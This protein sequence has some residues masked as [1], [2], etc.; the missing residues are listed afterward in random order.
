MTAAALIVA[1]GRG[2]RLGADLPKQ[3]IPLN[4]PCALRRSIELF[5]GAPGIEH[6]R[7]VI[8]PEDAELYDAAVETLRDDR[9]GPPVHGGAT[10]AASVRAGL[11]AMAQTPPEFVL[12]H[13]AARPFMP[14]PVI[15][16]VLAALAEHEGACAALPVVDAL[17]DAEDGLAHHPVSR[18]RLWRAQTPQGFRFAPILAAHRAHD[19]AG[20]DDVAVAL[21][22]G[23]S[24]RFVPGSEAGY[25]ITTGDDLARALRDADAR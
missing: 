19:G 7:T 5:L 14:V 3:Y 23:M 2:T 15:E 18:D 22:A 24:V 25:K 12:I 11:D 4:G 10:R 1:A 21:E 9:L 13:D 6:V 17:W 8:H 16:A 20:T